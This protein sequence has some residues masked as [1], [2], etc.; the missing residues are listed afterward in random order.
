[1]SLVQ[2][3]MDYGVLAIYSARNNMKSTCKAYTSAKPICS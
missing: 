1:M 3:S 2:H